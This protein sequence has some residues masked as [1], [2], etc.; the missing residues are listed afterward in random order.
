LII[1]SPPQV[2]GAAAHVVRFMKENS[3]DVRHD[4]EPAPAPDVKGPWYSLEYTF[5]I[6]PGIAK[7]PRAPISGKARGDRPAIERLKRA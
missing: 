3:N 5:R 2:R 1:W 4:N 7:W 6:E